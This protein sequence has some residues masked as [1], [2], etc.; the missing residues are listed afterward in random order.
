MDDLSSLKDDTSSVASDASIYSGSSH[1]RVQLLRDKQR[2]CN[3]FKKEYIATA[4]ELVQTATNEEFETILPELDAHRSCLHKAVHEYVTTAKTVAAIPE[5][6][7]LSILK[8]TNSALASIRKLWRLS[9]YLQPHEYGQNP[10]LPT[11]EEVYAD[12]ELPSTLRHISDPA[13]FELDPLMVEDVDFEES[14]Q[15]LKDFLIAMQT[16][17]KVAGNHPSAL[18]VSTH[19]AEVYLRES[20]V[21]ALRHIAPDKAAG[22]LSR[23]TEGTVTQMTPQSVAPFNETKSY[24][25]QCDQNSQR[26]DFAVS[27]VEIHEKGF[28]E[29]EKFNDHGSMAGSSPNASVSKSHRPSHSSKTP[30]REL[31]EG[32]LRLCMSNSQRHILPDITAV[33]A[34]LEDGQA[35][36]QSCISSSKTVFKRHNVAADRGNKAGVHF[37]QQTN[38]YGDDPSAPVE[39]HQDNHSSMPLTQRRQRGSAGS[40]LGLAHSTSSLTTDNYRVPVDE[41]LQYD[42]TVR[43]RELG[44]KEMAASRPEAPAGILNSADYIILR[45]KFLEASGNRC[46]SPKDKLR[47]LQRWFAK[48][49]SDLVDAAI[50]GV[51][52]ENAQQRLDECIENLDRLFNTRSDTLST[53]LN[54]ITNKGILQH[55]DF[56]GHKALCCSLIRAKAVARVCDSL[57]ECDQL[58]TLRSII[59]ARVPHLAK[60]FWSRRSRDDSPFT[61]DNLIEEIDFWATWNLKKGP[62]TPDCVSFEENCEVL[63]GGHQLHCY[64]SMVLIT[65]NTATCL[66]QC[67]T[68]TREWKS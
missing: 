9:K 25:Q 18:D 13:S 34:C 60:E 55:N 54:A 66:R 8:R 43:A 21:N 1:P 41:L 35:H 10:N 26:Q 37:H 61:L 38:T 19:E 30:S 3:F 16:S 29:A 36:R 15:Y 12:G 58:A 45:H 40:R 56:M 31:E 59:D 48:P 52:E 68:L 14:R 33:E 53:T 11:R 39:T 46:L 64:I 57:D 4:L 17:K 51:T 2:S 5:L 6:A 22:T 62:D 47:K 63:P 28:V 44:M 20:S 49:A 65:H 67:M 32:G 27:A 7:D 42:A 50:M 23:N 24:L